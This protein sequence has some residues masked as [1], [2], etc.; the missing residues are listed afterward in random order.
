[1]PT[2]VLLTEGIGFLASAVSFVLWWPQAARVWRHRRD[3]GRLGGVSITSQVLLVV[4]AA[5]WGGY[6][7]VTGSFWVGAPGLVNAPLA[8]GTIVLLRRSRRVSAT[9]GRSA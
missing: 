7:F 9:P 2:S 8:V 3:G 1:M 5:L 6:A 4:N